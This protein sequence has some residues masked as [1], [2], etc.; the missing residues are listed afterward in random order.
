[1]AKNSKITPQELEQFANVLQKY[2]LGTIIDGVAYQTGKSITDLSKMH[3]INF[4]TLHN[5]RNSR[6]PLVIQRLREITLPLCTD[7]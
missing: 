5:Y 4:Q 2:S 3:G 6:E 7:E 1:M